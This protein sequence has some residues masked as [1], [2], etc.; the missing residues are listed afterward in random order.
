MLLLL[1]MVRLHL[2][3]PNSD[4]GVIRERER[5]YASLT[6]S[7]WVQMFLSYATFCQVISLAATSSALK[8][9]VLWKHWYHC[10]DDDNFFVAHLFS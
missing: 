6:A 3:L 10:L 1:S 5:H 9:A 7:D 4:T 2:A 8:T